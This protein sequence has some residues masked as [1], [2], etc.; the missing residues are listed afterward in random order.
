MDG[1]EERIL[2]DEESGG[3]PSAREMIQ[4]V[5]GQPLVQVAASCVRRGRGHN[6]VELR[7]PLDLAYL[8][9]LRGTAGVIAG[10]RS[11]TYDEVMQLR[12]GVSEVFDVALRH[13]ARLD[14]FAKGNEIAFHFIAEPD[15]LQVIATYA[16]DFT[17]HPDTDEELKSQALLVSLLDDV[18]YQA[19]ASGGTLVR[20]KKQKSESKQ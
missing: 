16:G 15:G 9:V 8:P 11:F 5:D 18:Q 19:T 2:V 12:V 3:W 1:E 17:A 13:V 7:V 10:T 4:L 14:R 6:V 20:I